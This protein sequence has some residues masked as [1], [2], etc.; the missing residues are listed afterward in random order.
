MLVRK[1]SKKWREVMAIYGG[2]CAACGCAD[3]GALHIDHVRARTNSGGNDLDNLQVL[4]GACNLAK[5]AAEIKLPP[6]RGKT[7]GAPPK[8]AHAARRRWAVAVS[9]AKRAQGIK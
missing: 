2:A 7:W 3:M 1:G 8:A 9:R 4:C 6:W 5:G